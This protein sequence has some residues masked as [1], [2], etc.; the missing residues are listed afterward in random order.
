MEHKNDP[1]KQEAAQIIN[2]IKRQGSIDFAL[3]QAEACNYLIKAFVQKQDFDSVKIVSD[4]ASSIE[5][6]TGEK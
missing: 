3:G 5:V 1:I 6:S 2:A 4:Y